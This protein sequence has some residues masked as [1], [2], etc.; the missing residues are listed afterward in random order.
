VTAPDWEARLAQ[1]LAGDG[2]LGGGAEIE[3]LHPDGSVAL[4][5]PLARH[6]RV[7]DDETGP[8]VVWIRPVVAGY[9]PE[10]E[11]GLPPY[12]FHLNEA[13]PRALQLAGLEEV[14]HELVFRTAAAQLVRIRPA[15][16]Q[17]LLEL[18]RWDT[19]C[20][21]VLSAE[22]EAALDRVWGDSWWGDWA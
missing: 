22:D 3:V 1:L 11:R 20:A 13:R 15:G 8:P 19:F 6:H 4:L 5:A 12:A 10:G 7:E 17:T 18:E 16:P 14:G 2:Q 21:V 9:A